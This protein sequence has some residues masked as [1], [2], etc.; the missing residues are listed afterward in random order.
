MNYKIFSIDGSK[1]ATDIAI[2][3]DPEDYDQ[4]L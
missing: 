4:I 1:L 2:Q 3:L